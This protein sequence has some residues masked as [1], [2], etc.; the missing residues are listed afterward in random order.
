MVIC[1]NEIAEQAED[2][3]VQ[4]LRWSK[5]GRRSKDFDDACDVTSVQGHA[6]DFD[7]IRPWTDRLATRELFEEIYHKV[8]SH[9]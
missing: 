7:D 5:T 9:S 6:L 2:V 1:V 8:K 3:I 4:K